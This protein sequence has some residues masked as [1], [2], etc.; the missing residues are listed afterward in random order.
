[1]KDVLRA[2][3]RL[4]A[5][6][7]FFA[8]AFVFVMAGIVTGAIAQFGVALGTAL[9]FLAAGAMTALAAKLIFPKPQLQEALGGLDG[10]QFAQLAEQFMQGFQV[11]MTA[12]APPQPPPAPA[13]S[14]PN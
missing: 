3:K 11:G 2:K 13:A 1:M 6:A 14:L 7:V 4:I 10:A 9:G 5:S 8:A 12:E